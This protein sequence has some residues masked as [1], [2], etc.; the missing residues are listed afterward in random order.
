M[1]ILVSQ[2]FLDIFPTEEI[3]H[4]SKAVWVA[5]GSKYFAY[6]TFD[7]TQVMEHLIT[8]WI[9]V[10]YKYVDE[11]QSLA[12]KGCLKNKKNWGISPTLL[13]PNVT[14]IF[15]LISVTGAWRP[16]RLRYPVAGAANPKVSSNIRY[17]QLLS[18][19]W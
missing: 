11:E 18:S 16:V 10:M 4:S 3:L 17:H 6:A 8:R 14:Q 13:C 5:P 19:S 12:A 1:H 7:D 2:T 9:S 15:C